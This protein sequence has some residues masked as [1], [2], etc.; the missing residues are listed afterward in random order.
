MRKSKENSK[1]APQ[2]CS[3]WEA[4]GW[5]ASHNLEKGFEGFAGF[6]TKNNRIKTINNNENLPEILITKQTLHRY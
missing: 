6:V 1:A 4:A 2:P 5:L 3:R